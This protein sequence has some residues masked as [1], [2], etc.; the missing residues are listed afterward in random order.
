MS[1]WLESVTVE[2]RGQ[3]TVV[4]AG[5]VVIVT[6][7][8]KGIGRA[9][10]RLFAQHGAKVALAA[11]STHLLNALADELPGALAVTVDMRDL[12]VIGRMVDAVKDRYGR[13][14]VLVNNA[15]LLPILR[16]SLVV[17]L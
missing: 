6:G 4:I 7:A 12:E 13:I 17:R 8:S 10:A 11:G 5:K 16:R 2:A 3:E 1:E 14:D 15:G 9:T